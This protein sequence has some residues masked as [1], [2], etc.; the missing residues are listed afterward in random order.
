M[1]RWYQFAL[2]GSKLPTVTHS[3]YYEPKNDYVTLK[4]PVIQC[5]I[6]DFHR[7]SEHLYYKFPHFQHPSEI[8]I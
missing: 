7:K 2:N 6:E 5:K 3:R 8:C 1:F 4:A